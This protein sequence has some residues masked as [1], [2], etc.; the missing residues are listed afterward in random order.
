MSPATITALAAIFGSLVG[1]LGSSLST[2]ITQT[3]EDRRNLLA[4]TIFH[5]EQL[6]SEFISESA[7]ILIDALE[8]NFKD[9]NQLIPAYAL[10][11]RI[12]LSSST[13]VLAS[14]EEVI[15]RIIDTYAEPNLTPEQIQLM[16][17]NGADPLKD[18]G[19]V[20]RTEL[21]SMQRQL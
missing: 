5:R 17:R 2:W 18:F 19:E 4:Q 10:V 15:R 12:R 14:A 21:E 11:S 3:H 16:A 20:C 6:Y 7:R 13:V 1:A 9:A 8:H